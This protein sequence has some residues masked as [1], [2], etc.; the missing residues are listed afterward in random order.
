[1]NRSW[2]NTPIEWISRTNELLER[3][4]C[5]CSRMKGWVVCEWI[6][7]LN[8]SSTNEWVSWINLVIGTSSSWNNKCLELFV[9]KRMNHLITR[10]I[11]LQ[12]KL[13]R[14]TETP[15]WISGEWIVKIERVAHEWMN[16][17]TESFGNDWIMRK[18]RSPPYLQ[19]S[20]NEFIVFYLADTLCTWFVN[21]WIIRN[22]ERYLKKTTQLSDSWD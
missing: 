13:S 2:T 11:R 6:Q 14:I 15:W 19:T 3:I 1:M 5:N 4:V 18:N 10:T 20:R 9:G 7:K 21:E 22:F 8:E 17:F 12:T 16:H